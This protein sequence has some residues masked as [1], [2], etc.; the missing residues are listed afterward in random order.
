MSKHT[1]YATVIGGRQFEG[2]LS[3]DGPYIACG[4][5]GV[6][7]GSCTTIELLS[8]DLDTG[9]GRHQVTPN[10]WWITK[11]RTQPRI[12]LDGLSENERQQLADN[13]GIRVGHEESLGEPFW[14][15]AAFR[16]LAAWIKKHPR[17]AAPFR[18]YNAYLP[19]WYDAARACD[20]VSV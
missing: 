9:V 11:Y 8:P 7:L 2:V 1:F 16:S 18:E 19:G 17:V 3:A 4:I 13:F 5:D 15:S 14:D 10:S 12:P 6:A 20:V